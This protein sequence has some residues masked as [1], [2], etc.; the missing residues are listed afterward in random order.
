MARLGKDTNSVTNWLLSGTRNQPEPHVGMGVT[1]LMWTDRLAGTITAYEPGEKIF[2]FKLDKATRTDNNGMSEV[3]SYRY[4]PNPDAPEQMARLN[5][6]GEWRVG[7]AR[8]SVIR[9]GDRA[10]YHDYSF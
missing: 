1:V 5:S 10:A 2:W 3:Q 7:G 4:E 6:K 9:L 8:G